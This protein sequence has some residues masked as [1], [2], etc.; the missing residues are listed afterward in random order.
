MKINETGVRLPSRPPIFERVA[1]CKDAG[2]NSPRRAL[3]HTGSVYS[4]VAGSNPV[5]LTTFRHLRP[6]TTAVESLLDVVFI[7]L[8]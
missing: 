2:D 3:R 8:R 4:E 1:E 5:A 7:Q 6:E